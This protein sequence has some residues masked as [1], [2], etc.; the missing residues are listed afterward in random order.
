MQLPLQITFKN[1]ETSP[2]V[3]ARIRQ[4]AAKLER[5]AGRIGH[6]R[7][8][9]ETPHRRQR[10]GKIFRVSINLTLPPRHEIAI[11]RE[12]RQNQ[13]HEAIGVAIRDA[14]DAAV[15]RVEDHVRRFRGDVKS[16]EAPLAGRVIRVAADHGFVATDGGQEV[17][18]HENSV[19]GGGFAQLEVGSEVILVVAEGESPHGWQASTVQAVGKHHPA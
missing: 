17:Y 4:E 3:E 12:R 19:V 15:R 13:S 7:V 1:I 10:Q 9:I 5:F 16:H 18:F 8:V 14:F 2:A 11:G 6:C